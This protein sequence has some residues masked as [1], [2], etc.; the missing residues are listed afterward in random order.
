[1]WRNLSARLVLWLR[2]HLAEIRVPLT[3]WSLMLTKLQT[4]YNKAKCRFAWMLTGCQ[5]ISNQK[6]DR[7]FPSKNLTQYMIFLSALLMPIFEK[8]WCST[9]QHLDCWWLGWV[10]NVSH[11][12]SEKITLWW[13][14]SSRRNHLQK[15][16]RFVLLWPVRSCARWNLKDFMCNVYWNRAYELPTWLTLWEFFTCGP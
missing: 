7:V 2:A 16:N 3:E 11:F 9:L 6:I 1:M 8:C 13:S 5:Y 4:F 14:I 15:S 12:S 10:V